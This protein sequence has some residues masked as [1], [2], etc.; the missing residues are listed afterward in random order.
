MKAC[1]ICEYIC[2]CISVCLGY[3]GPCVCQCVCVCVALRKEHECFTILYELASFYFFMG[4]L[5]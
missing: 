2:V 5:L 4:E 3:K 1:N